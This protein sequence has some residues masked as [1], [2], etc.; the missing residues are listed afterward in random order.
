MGNSAALHIILKITI[1]PHEFEGKK[2]YAMSMLYKLFNLDI[3]GMS[4]K[5]LLTFHHVKTKR[6]VLAS[7]S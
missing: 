6:T 4:L 3:N 7:P 5:K 1:S 2:I